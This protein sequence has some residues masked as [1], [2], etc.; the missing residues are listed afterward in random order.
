M[1][2]LQ[3][4]FSGGQSATPALST[5]DV[6]NIP[7]VAASDAPGSWSAYL[8]PGGSV[9][10]PA[11]GVAPASVGSMAPIGDTGGF[12]IGKMIP[13]AVGGI[14]GLVNMFRK[15]PTDA[16]LK[17]MEKATGPM[18]AA[19]NQA[20][21]AYTSGT[22]TPTQ[23]AK[24]DEFKKQNLA[25]WRQYLASAGIPESSAMADIESKVNMDAQAYADT[26]LQQDFT[27]AYA[28]TGLTT[29]NL[30][31]V[32]R[33]QALQDAEQRKA[34]EDFMRELGAIGGDVAGGIFD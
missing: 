32:A 5:A 27:N 33:Q 10:T 20:L 8:P 19:G 26:L 24:V 28:A 23:Q 15:D 22:L 30:T 11:G 1:D 2:T 17:K 7:A 13:A 21:G 9:D 14:G 31:N 6:G 4:M 29:T 25:K 34:W 16:A 12:S 18:Q 3:G